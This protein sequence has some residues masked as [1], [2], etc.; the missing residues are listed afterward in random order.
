[1]KPGIL[2]QLFISFVGFGLAVA[3]IFP[4]YAEFFVKWK[5]GMYAWFVV[6][7]VVA[8]VSI[9]FANYFLVHLVLLSKL[10]RIAEVAQ[11]I[12]NKDITHEC[13]LESRDLIG[14]II[15]AF[16]AMAST[17]RSVI[18]QIG[19]NAGQLDTAS[20]SVFEAMQNSSEEV[21]SQQAQIEHMATAMNQ[22]AVSAQDVARHTA[23]AATAMNAADEQGDTAKVVIVEA[24]CAVDELADKVEQ[25]S[26]A[27][28]KLEQDSKHID[29]VVEVINGIA[30]Q[31]NL[32][33]L[34]AA[35]EAAR[36]GEQGRGFAVVADE[37]RTLATRTQQSTREI[38]ELL[39]LLLAG[40]KQ[41]STVMQDGG[42]QA[43]K[44]V[45]L[46]ERAVEAMSEVAGAITTI[47]D[48]NIQIASAAEEQSVVIKEVNQNIGNINQLS[49]QSRE[50]LQRVSEASDQVSSKASE[51]NG[52]VSEFKV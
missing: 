13:T 48:M 11:A 15:A 7:C 50:N 9:G 8:G 45:E 28:D 12:G 36:A 41:A 24:M 43:R 34:N 35:I 16:N 20:T 14:E 26:G 30:E 31:T 10:K 4:F 29:S 6:G 1:M 18:N 5:P 44:G 47:K 52:L 38:S 42:E 40:S 46:T 3:I 21:Q 49:Q 22:M 17:L 25:A 32:L 23:E 51:L 27:I 33:A 39:D 19:D 37:V 2:R